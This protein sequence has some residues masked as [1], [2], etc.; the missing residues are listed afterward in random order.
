LK[1]FYFFV[2]LNTKFLQVQMVTGEVLKKR[3][4]EMGLDVAT[5]ADL[6]KIRADYLSSIEDSLFEKLPPLV[7]TLGYVRSYACYLGVDADALVQYYSEHLSLPSGHTTIIPIGYSQKRIP[8]FLAVIP[9][10]LLAVAAFIVFPLFQKQAAT[11]PVSSNKVLAE[12]KVPAAHDEGNQTLAAPA[13]P[14]QNSGVVS[15]PAV[16]EAGIIS[17]GVKNGQHSLDITVLDTTWMS[18]KFIDGKTEEV[19]FRPGEEKRWKFSESAF[20]RVGNAGGIKLRF[21]GEDLGAPGDPGQVKS[22]TLPLN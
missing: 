17:G 16:G 2:M 11:V 6:L 8:K 3:R 19:L 10:L 13:T 22:L 7:Y 20:I 4:E 18:I 5:V 9:V 21:D 12:K 14:V 1:I 15:N